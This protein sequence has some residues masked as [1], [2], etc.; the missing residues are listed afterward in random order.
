[1]KVSFKLALALVG[2]VVVVM[3]GYAFFQIR[4]EV[5]ILD[6]ELR[7]N[8]KFGMGAAAAIQE[9]WA[10]DGEARA[11]HILETIDKNG[12]D[13]IQLR[14]VWLDDL[15][16]APPPGFTPK[17]F[18][19]LAE[20]TVVTV[21][22]DPNGGWLRYI[23]VPLSVPGQRPAVVQV[24]ES[25]SAEKRFIDMNRLQIALSTL[26]VATV[27]GLT[28]IGLGHW[29]VGRP[30]A[31]LRDHARAIG[32]GDLSARVP[33]RQRDELGELAAELNTMSDQLATT[34]ARLTAE[35][36]ARIA[37]LEQLRHTDRLTTVGRLAAGI[38]HE[39]GTPLNV[40][41]AR[42]ARILGI[43][44][45]SGPSSEYARIIHEQASRM[46]SVIRQ[47][48]DFSRRQGP[49]L[50]LCD[51]RTLAARTVELLAPLGKKQGVTVTLHADEALLARVDQNQMQQALANVMINGIQAMPN[52]GRLVVTIGSSEAP[53]PA[54]VDAEAGR[55]QRPCITV[56]D[57]GHG[58]PPENLP[59]IFEPFF[60]TKGV[61]EGTGLGL[62][63]A[64]G[65]V[66]D[67]GGWI[68]VQTEIGR[69]TRITLVLG[70]TAAGTAEVAS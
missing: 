23:Y 35:T 48:L 12:P 27:C 16:A 28:A 29:F 31:D 7:K 67:H 39:L 49:K 1:M 44:G 70:A 59:H 40:I 66:S 52:G 46:T 21:Q 58:I 19:T 4:R 15:R 41:S 22:P 2:G 17:D 37:T 60:T 25:L 33:I 69:G 56:E 57:E 5:V 32:R 51:L 30:M 47:L 10:S 24:R 9:I 45:G 42:A 53:P 38:A 54:G 50:G 11:R 13:V 61:G 26:L 14:W 62:S 43:E 36:E 18:Q 20:R 55:G 34:Q 6:A 63:V 3:A 8:H 65:I 64:H 68:D